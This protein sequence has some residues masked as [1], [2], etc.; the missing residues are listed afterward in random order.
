MQDFDYLHTSIFF[1]FF[2]KG[3]TLICTRLKT[4][5][6][7]KNLCFLWP[8]ILYL[9]NKAKE[10]KRLRAEHEKRMAEL[11]AKAIIPFIQFNPLFQ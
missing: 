2:F 4:L 11:K 1:F 7:T 6:Y 10:E 9:F 8:W 3:Q 5:N